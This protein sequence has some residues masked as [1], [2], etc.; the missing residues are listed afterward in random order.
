MKDNCFPSVVLAAVYWARAPR[1]VLPDRALCL[2][3][4][5]HSLL[6][7]NKSSSFSSSACRCCSCFYSSWLSRLSS[8]ENPFMC[9]YMCAILWATVLQYIMCVRVRKYVIVGIHSSEYNA[10]CVFIASHHP[11]SARCVIYILY[12]CACQLQFWS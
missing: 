10:D 4:F 5:C 7:V 8:S 3:T 12:I 11:H 9:V 2:P 6:T 1:V